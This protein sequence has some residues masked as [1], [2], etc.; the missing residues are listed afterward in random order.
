MHVVNLI[1]KPSQPAVAD[2]VRT[3][4]EWGRDA[5]LLESIAL[6]MCFVLLKW[7]VSE[8]C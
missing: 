4:S 7:Q 2:A 1:L 5:N 8:Q 3:H 6:K